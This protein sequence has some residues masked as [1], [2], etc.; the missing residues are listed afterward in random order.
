[1]SKAGDEAVEAIRENMEIE[2][3]RVQAQ[4]QAG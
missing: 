1:V 4:Q 3:H 2:D